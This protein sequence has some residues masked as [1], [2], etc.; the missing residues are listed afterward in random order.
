[1]DKLAASEDVLLQPSLLKKHRKTKEWQSAIMLWKQELDFFQKLL[2]QH[3]AK[4]TSIEDKKRIDHFQNLIIYYKGELLNNFDTKLRL[5]EKRLA[6]LTKTVDDLKAEYNKEHNGLMDELESL[7]T[8][9][10]K[11]HGELL[12]FME[13]AV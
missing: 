7:N 9:F 5:H 13:K 4:F 6:E 2:D 12:E 3:S 10:H 1:M 11:Y 8:Q